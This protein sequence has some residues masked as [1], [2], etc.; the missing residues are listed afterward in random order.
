M[1]ASQR[2]QKGSAIKQTAFMARQ[3]NAIKKELETVN[4]SPSRASEMLGVSSSDLLGG[5]A[6]SRFMTVPGSARIRGSLI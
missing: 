6:R 1:N 2:H 5:L 3:A 4:Y